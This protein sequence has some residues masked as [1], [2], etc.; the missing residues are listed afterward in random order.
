MNIFGA[1]WICDYIRNRIFSIPSGYK[2]REV[3]PLRVGI[4]GIL[5]LTQVGKGAANEIHTT[6]TSAGHEMMQKALSSLGQSL[7]GNY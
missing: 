6:E 1:F 5:S 4:G 2:I 3:N 7:V